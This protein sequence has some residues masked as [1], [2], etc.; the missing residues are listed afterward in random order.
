MAALAS[1]REMPVATN[2]VVTIKMFPALP[3]V[4]GSEG[5]LEETRCPEECV[6]E[7]MLGPETRRF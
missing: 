7:G 1:T 3:E 4:P 6:K 5:T 2:P